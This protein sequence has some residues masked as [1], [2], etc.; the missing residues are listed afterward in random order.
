[1]ALALAAACGGS[2]DGPPPPLGRH[3]QESFIAGLPV[4]QQSEV[5]KTQS[6][7]N[8]AQREQAK[9]EADQREQKLQLDV[10]KNEARAAKLDL[11]S[12]TQ[13]E[14]MAQ[15]SA[16]MNRINEA[17][18]E[19]RGA[20]LARNA[21]DERVKYYQAYGAWLHRLLRYTQ[22]NTYWRESQYELAKAR[23]AQK[24]NIAPAGFNYDNFVQ[25]EQQRAKRVQAAKAKA[26]GAK[27]AALDARQRWLVLQGE[28]DKTLGK[29]SEFP[30][31]MSP[32]PVEGT[33]PTAGSGGSTIGGTSSGS[34]QQ[35][36][37]AEDSTGAGNGSE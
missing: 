3:F 32:R 30:D 13:R 20:E 8:V 25:Q 5:I 1:M 24:N 11:D 10:A 22:E 34:D 21:A 9:A 7:Y 29:K 18:R 27:G 26:D 37:P 36:P 28:A 35:V 31:P 19:K 16:D 6:D 14:K 17:T 4:D 15:Q 23:L 12:A 33:D 2:S